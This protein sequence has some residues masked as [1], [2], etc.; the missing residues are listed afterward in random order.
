MAAIFP[1]RLVF[2]GRPTY[3]PAALALAWGRA[4]LSPRMCACRCCSAGAK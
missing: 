2:S 4:G 3:L 1:L